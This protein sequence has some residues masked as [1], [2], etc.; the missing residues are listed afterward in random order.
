M[1]IFIGSLMALTFGELIEGSYIVKL[2]EDARIRMEA[3]LD[4]VKGL[5]DSKAPGNSI[6]S[7]YRN[8]GSLYHAEFSDETKDKVQ[9]LPEVELIEP[10][11]TVT[12]D[13]VQADAP[14][15]L[16]RISS[17]NKLTGSSYNYTYLGDG[18]G[19]TVYVVDTGIMVDHPEFEGRAR[20]GKRF[21]GTNDL[22]ENGH[23]THCAGTIASKT[24][25]VAKRSSLVAVRVLDR[26]GSGSSS[27]VL[28]GINWAVGDKRGKKGN[29]I[30]MSLGGGKSKAL[31]AAVEAATNKG[32]VVVVAGGND[33]RDACNYSPASAPSAITVA[34]SDINDRRAAFSNYGRC[35]DV[36]APGVNIKSTWNNKGT[37][38]ISGTSMATPHVAGLAA[39]LLSKNHLSPDRLAAEINSLANKDA[40]VNPGSGSP[41]RLVFNNA[42]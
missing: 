1:G 29:I 21:A 13:A 32:L 22:D 5:F 18:A 14:W 37:N 28:S 24:Y 35:I 40:I 23:G 9:A 33:N 12:I 38:I 6:K 7:V 42:V 26:R 8:L 20:F 30:S 25:G 3:H 10:D 36:F 31:N 2:K 34:A 41:N 27:G 11:A 19:V 16:A 39:Y 17:R 15:G 4:T